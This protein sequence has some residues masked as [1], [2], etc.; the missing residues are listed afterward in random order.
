MIKIFGIS[1]NVRFKNDLDFVF[2]EVYEWFVVRCLHQLIKTKENLVY[3]NTS[4]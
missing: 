4:N 1:M 3:R 2:Y